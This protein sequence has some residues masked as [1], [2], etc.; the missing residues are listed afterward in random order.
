MAMPAFRSMC[1]SGV[2]R[3]TAF[4]YVDENT[5]TAYTYLL[6]IVETSVFTRRIGDCMSDEEWLHEEE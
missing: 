6:L 1:K 2:A 3:D 4:R 5:P